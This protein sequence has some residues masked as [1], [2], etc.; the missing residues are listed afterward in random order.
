MVFL[1]LT[2]P[3]F[4]DLRPRV[5]AGRDAVWVNRGV[6]SPGEVI[7]LRASGWD[8]T[9]FADPLAPA[10]LPAAV[11]TLRGHHPDHVVWVEAVAD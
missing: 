5:V 7:A 8:L 6:L 11:E 3:G 2:R 1:V 4:D 9:T 10:A